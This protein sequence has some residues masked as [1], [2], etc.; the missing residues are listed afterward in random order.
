MCRVALSPQQLLVNGTRAMAVKFTI[1][2]KISTECQNLRRSICREKVSFTKMP[3]LCVFEPPPTD[4][5]NLANITGP[6]GPFP[7]PPALWYVASME[8][9]DS[10]FGQMAALLHPGAGTLATID[11]TPYWAHLDQLGTPV[12]LTNTDGNAVWEAT[13][14]PFGETVSVN[15]DPD[16]DGTAVTMNIRLPGQYFDAE[17][18]LNYN[19]HRYYDP[20]VG[21]YVQAEPL[22]FG[23]TPTKSFLYSDNNPLVYA[24]D[25]GWKPADFGQCT[26]SPIGEEIWGMFPMLGKSSL[27]GFLC[28]WDCPEGLDVYY[29]TTLFRTRSLRG[30]YVPQAA[31]SRHPN[32][33]CELAINPASFNHGDEIERTCTMAHEQCHL[34]DIPLERTECWARLVSRNCQ[35]ALRGHPDPNFEEH[36]REECIGGDPPGFPSCPE[37]GYP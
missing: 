10:D 27:S 26:E 6:A 25:L 9:L 33:Y 23:E 36:A 37:I 13:F 28:G 30:S 11:Y 7:T 16:G 3:D 15:E 20:A 21:R 18:G 32:G 8:V 24:D 2:H 17:T 1:L 29:C 19:W 35:A 12:M 22:S 31:A 14:A 4:S 5:P 34:S